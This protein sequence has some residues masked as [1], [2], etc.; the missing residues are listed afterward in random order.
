LIPVLGNIIIG[1]SD[2]IY[3]PYFHKDSLL[4][5]VENDG[6]ELRNASREL[7]DDK[8]VVCAA[9]TE[10]PISFKY[11]SKERQ[12]DDDVIIATINSKIRFTPPGFLD[13]L[14]ANG[15][16]SNKNIALAL[17]QKHGDLYLPD[18]DPSLQNDED[19]LKALP[20]TQ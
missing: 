13:S 2:W 19:I 20:A 6:R 12:S 9:V 10:N 18:V 4:K 11:A 5:I 1:L 16:M 14:K 15:K 8:D 7:R 3:A 17:V